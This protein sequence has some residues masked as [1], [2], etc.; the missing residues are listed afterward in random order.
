MNMFGDVQDIEQKNR[1][2]EKKKK[3][4]CDKKKFIFFDFFHTC[5]DE[6]KLT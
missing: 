4:N 6:I 5:F 2:L 1:Q 3:S